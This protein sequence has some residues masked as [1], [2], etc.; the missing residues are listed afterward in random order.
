MKRLN[1]LKDNPKA[2]IREIFKITELSVFTGKIKQ[3]IIIGRE[4]YE[5]CFDFMHRKFL[6]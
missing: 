5:T 4:F 6:P 1:Y 2:V 3:D